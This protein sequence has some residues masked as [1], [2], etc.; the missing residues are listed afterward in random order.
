MADIDLQGRPAD[1]VPEPKE[2][3]AA[4]VTEQVDKK[5][6]PAEE[7]KLKQTSPMIEL[8]PSVNVQGNELI[9]L[10]QV[11]SSINRNLAFMARTIHEFV[12]REEKKN[13]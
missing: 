4:K 2:D 3:T 8:R 7:Q 12:N 11:L 13:G 9:V 10:V 1:E 6:L 5:P